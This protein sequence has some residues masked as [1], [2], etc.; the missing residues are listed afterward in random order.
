[1][2]CEALRGCRLCAANVGV[3]EQDLVAPDA[4]VECRELPPTAHH[5]AC[6]DDEHEREG[7]LS[8]DQYLSHPE[9]AVPVGDTAPLCLHGGLW[10][11]AT[12]APRRHQAEQQ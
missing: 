12:R 1:M 6:G 3:D 11:H 8:D 7:D 4:R 2:K 5:Q 10:I 9:A